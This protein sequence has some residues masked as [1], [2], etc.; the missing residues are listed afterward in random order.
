MNEP[1]RIPIHSSLNRN[2]LLLGGERELVLLAALT[3]ALVVVSGMNKISFIAG[4]LI[5]FSLMLLL[6]KMAKADPV[7]SKVYTRHIKYKSFYPAKAGA[8]AESSL[9]ASRKGGL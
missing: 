5:W 6:I 2:Q 4:A 7:M 8:F 1:R 9:P 3:V